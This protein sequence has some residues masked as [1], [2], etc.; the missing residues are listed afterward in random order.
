[1][2]VIAVTQ[3]ISSFCLHFSASGDSSSRA[4]YVEISDEFLE[5]NL[6]N[7]NVT[8]PRFIFAELGKKI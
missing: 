7:D 1:M 3:L 5:N 2:I 8:G 6:G 4:I